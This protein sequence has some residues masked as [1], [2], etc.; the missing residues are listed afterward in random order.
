VLSH[1]ATVLLVVAA[2]AFAT[3]AAAYFLLAAG[4]RRGIADYYGE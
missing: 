4:C 1:I 2:S 3:I